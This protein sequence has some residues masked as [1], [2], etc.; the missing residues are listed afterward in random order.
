VARR[1]EG[2]LVSI[3]QNLQFHADSQQSLTAL[4]ISE[5]NPTNTTN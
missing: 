5:I 2:G 4:K 1:A 3:P